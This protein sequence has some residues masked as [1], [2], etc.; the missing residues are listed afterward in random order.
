MKFAEKYL[1]DLS[2]KSFFTGLVDYIILGPVVAMI[3][4]NKN[5]VTTGSKIIGATNPSDSALGS[6]RDDL[7]FGIGRNVIHGSDVNGR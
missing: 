5:V 3:W 6:I 1:E 7:A 2:S 4:E